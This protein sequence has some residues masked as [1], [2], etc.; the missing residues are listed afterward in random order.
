[1]IVGT[2]NARH[3]LVIRMPVQDATE[4]EQEIE[5]VL[6]TGFTGSFTLRPLKWLGMA[7]RAGHDVRARVEAGGRVEIEAIP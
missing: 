7:L 6:D 3:E 1:M 4:Q 2:V 5:A